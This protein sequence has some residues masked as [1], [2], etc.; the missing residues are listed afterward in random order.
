MEI[1]VDVVL[2]VRAR[3]LAWASPWFAV[4][5]RQP[6]DRV[7]GREAQNLLFNSCLELC[8]SEVLQIFVCICGNIPVMRTPL[9]ILFLILVTDLPPSIALGARHFTSRER[10]RLERILGPK[11]SLVASSGF[12]QGSLRGLE[13]DASTSG[14]VLTARERRCADAERGG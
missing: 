10:K 2:A 13:I 7:E 12:A 14:S 6:R 1:E 5:H 4:G 9:Q 11:T 3:T 8:A